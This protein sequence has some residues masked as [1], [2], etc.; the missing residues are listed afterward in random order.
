[1]H[2][3]NGAMVLWSG[4]Y[5]NSNLL[6]TVLW[7]FIF[8]WLP[9][10]SHLAT[11]TSTAVVIDRL[12]TTSHSSQRK[13]LSEESLAATAGGGG[14]VDVDVVVLSADGLLDKRLLEYL[15]VH[16][17]VVL[18]LHQVTLWDTQ[19]TRSP[20]FIT[21]YNTPSVYSWALWSSSALGTMWRLSSPWRH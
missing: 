21:P 13:D 6:L 8:K 7:P 17:H 18:S 11:D 14:V 5:V 15:S 19:S 12:R 9:V 16:L 10:L 2:W 3:F 1:M 4:H 20:P